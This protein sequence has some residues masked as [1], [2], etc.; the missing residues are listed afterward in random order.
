MGLTTDSVKSGFL[1]LDGVLSMTGKRTFLDGAQTLQNNDAL[2]G[3][4]TQTA[5]RIITGPANPTPGQRIIIKDF[6][7]VASGVNTVTFAPASGTIDG[8]ANK[9]VINAAYGVAE[10]YF[11]GTNWFTI[12]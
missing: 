6:G 3:Y 9:V 8:V 12:T 2:V 4:T 5:A 11:D 10:I 7:G 1:Q